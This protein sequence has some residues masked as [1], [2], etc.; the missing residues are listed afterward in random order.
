MVCRLISNL[1]CKQLP[2]FTHADFRHPGCFLKNHGIKLKTREINKPIVSGKSHSQCLEEEA[3]KNGQAGAEHDLIA[4]LLPWY[5]NGTLNPAKQALVVEHLPVCAE[6]RTILGQYQKL[7]AVCRAHTD[8]TDWQPSPAHFA[9]IYQNIDAEK[10]ETVAKSSTVS[11]RR[12][13]TRLSNRL[14]AVSRPIAWALTLETIALAVLVVLLVTPRIALQPTGGRMFETLSNSRAPV[15]M[16]Q[17]RVHIVF[18][19]DISEREIR[20]LLT[21]VQGRLIDGPSMLGVYTLAISGEKLD[22][23]LPRLR[24]HPK[25]KLAEPAAGTL[26]S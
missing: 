16:G 24:N 13:L 7:D 20:A 1:R 2:H 21:S 9:L 10:N 15:A 12:L 17:A 14:T 5:A 6:C 23:A 22:S 4:E 11:K 3:L 18:A 26:P 19:E 8:E 25:V